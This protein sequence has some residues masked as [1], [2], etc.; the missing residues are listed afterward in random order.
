MTLTGVACGKTEQASNRERRSC[1]RAERSFTGENLKETVVVLFLR[2]GLRGGSFKKGKSLAEG[3][4]GG[5]DETQSCTWKGLIREIEGA[6]V[7]SKEEHSM[8]AI[9]ATFCGVG[10][11]RE[12]KLVLGHREGRILQHEW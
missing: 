11:R 8:R 1:L 3:K 5:V 4:R 6:S 7:D 9:H 12:V 10:T 2:K